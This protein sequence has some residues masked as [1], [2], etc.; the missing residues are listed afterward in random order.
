M[1]ETIRLY[2]LVYIIAPDRS[3]EQVRAVIDKY[4]N[5]IASQGGTVDKTDIWERRRLA[6]EID[7]Y[8][9]G[10]YVV[11]IFRAPAGAEAE[12]RRV[13]RISEDTLRSIIVRPGEETTLPEPS[14]QGA[15]EGH[16][17]RAPR[18]ATAERPPQARAEQ[19]ETKDVSASEAE[20]VDEEL[21]APADTA[22][23]ADEADEAEPAGV[24]S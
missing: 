13:F 20:S 9:E 8:T 21:A 17:R 6:Y 19:A 23:D 22:S 10:L 11:T 5:L 4:N 3:E 1:P 16:G 12:L 15:D 24:T 18:A 2:E 7:G 14:R